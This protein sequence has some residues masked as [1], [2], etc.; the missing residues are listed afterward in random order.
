MP[1]LRW[2]AGI[3]LLDK[4]PNEYIRGSSK[5]ESISEKLKEIHLTWYNHVMGRPDEHVTKK[6]L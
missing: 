4:V 1:M 6:V 5:V 3:S 2:F